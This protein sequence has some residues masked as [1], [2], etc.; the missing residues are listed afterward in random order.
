MV[1]LSPFCGTDMLCQFMPSD[2]LEPSPLPVHTWLDDALA[3]VGASR[4]AARTPV[5][6]ASVPAAAI[7]A[8][9]AWL[10]RSPAPHRYG[11]RWTSRHGGSWPGGWA[12]PGCRPATTP[13]SAA[14]PAAGSPG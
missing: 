6:A 2:Q 13:G 14:F 1:T 9:L 8:R 10:L 5:P 12:R 7:V 3:A 4:S 11:Q